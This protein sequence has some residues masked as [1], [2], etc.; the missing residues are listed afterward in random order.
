VDLALMRGDSQPG[1]T[2]L[3]QATWTRGWLDAHPGAALTFDAAVDGYPG[4]WTLDTTAAHSWT[5]DVRSDSPS[6]TYS[7][8]VRGTVQ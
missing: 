3:Q 4:S 5:F 7:T 2:T 1:T 8:S 6:V